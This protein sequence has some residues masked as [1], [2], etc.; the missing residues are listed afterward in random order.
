MKNILKK[1]RSLSLRDAK[2]EE[3]SMEGPET[4]V[5]LKFNAH[6]PQCCKKQVRNCIKKARGVVS[7]D[8]NS[9]R[10]QAEVTGT[11]RVENLKAHIFK[12]LHKHVEIVSQTFATGE[13][14]NDR[15][16]KE[17]D[18]S[19]DDELHVED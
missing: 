9:E 16:D 5:V 2:R 4:I 18:S 14:S 6:C 7:V 15:D 17:R 11:F 3:P 8:V 12:D 10:E 19:S 1:L 13:G